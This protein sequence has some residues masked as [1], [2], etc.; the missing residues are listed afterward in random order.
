MASPRPRGWDG[1][2][3]AVFYDEEDDTDAGIRWN[4]STRISFASL[5]VVQVKHH[6]YAVDTRVDRGGSLGYV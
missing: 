4:K 1:A 2:G 3:P 6:T 5:L